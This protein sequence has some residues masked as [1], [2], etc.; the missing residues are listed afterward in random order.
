MLHWMGKKS[1][2][3]VVSVLLYEINTNTLELEVV[4]NMYLSIYNKVLEDWLEDDIW[5][6]FFFLFKACGFIL[7]HIHIG[8][9]SDE[10]LNILWL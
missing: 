4:L 1:P 2:C 3:R 5:L 8:S 10:D 7:C 6:F 9:I